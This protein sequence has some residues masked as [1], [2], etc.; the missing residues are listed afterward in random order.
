MLKR[1]QTLTNKPSNRRYTP[2]DRRYTPEDRRY[3]PK[4]RRHTPKDRRYTPEDRRYTPEAI[5]VFEFCEATNFVPTLVGQPRGSRI[6]QLVLQAYSTSQEKHELLVI[7]LL[8]R[9]EQRK[10]PGTWLTQHDYV[11]QSERL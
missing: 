5:V 9:P 3:T 6:S 10:K 2:E 7:Q 8:T 1:R 11:N 4:D